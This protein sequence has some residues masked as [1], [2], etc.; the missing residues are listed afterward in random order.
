MS[1]AANA[2]PVRAVSEPLLADTT[3]W[4]SL[5][6]DLHNDFRTCVIGARRQQT[7]RGRRIELPPA[8]LAALDEGLRQAA[9]L[10]GGPP[11]ASGMVLVESLPQLQELAGRLYVQEQRTESD[12]AAMGAYYDV[13][14]S[15]YDQHNGSASERLTQ[16]VLELA[17]GAGAAWARPVVEGGGSCLL[18]DLGSGTGLSSVAARSCM[19]SHGCARP[20]VVGCDVSLGMLGERGYSRDEGACAADAGSGRL[21]FRSGR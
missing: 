8:R 20:A 11:P 17:A 9:K 18:L 10:Q 21:P 4:A 16:R 3:V 6:T 2:R 14:S 19:T 13:R 1:A 7:G 5:G 15:G 12:G